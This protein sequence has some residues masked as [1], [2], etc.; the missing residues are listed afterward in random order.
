MKASVSIVFDNSD[1]D[2]SPIG[3]EECPEITV[4][5]QVGRDASTRRSTVA[6]LAQRLL[7]AR[8]LSEDAISTLS[9]GA[10]RRLGMS[11]TLCAGELTHR[12]AFCCPQ[13]SVQSLPLRA[14]QHPQPA[15]PHYA[16]SHYQGAKHEA[17]GRQC[18][19]RCVVAPLTQ[20][21]WMVLSGNFGAHYGSCGHK[22][23]RD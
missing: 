9:T 10:Q 4:T 7:F 20:I 21:F 3:Y 15:F 16:G 18:G 22:H 19:R 12:S 8:L 23:V 5:R 6:Q 17:Q 11:N 2:T 13:S 14:A 1:R